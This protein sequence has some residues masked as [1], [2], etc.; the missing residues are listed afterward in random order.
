MELSRGTPP[1]SHPPRGSLDSTVYVLVTYGIYFAA[2]ATGDRQVW[3]D[4]GGSRYGW[5]SVPAASASNQTYVSGSTF[6]PMTASSSFTVTVWQNS[7]GNL[8]IGNGSSTL[9]NRC[10]VMVL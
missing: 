6:L 4:Y 8:I 1:P 2:N 10:Q 5:Q 3:I 7:G 9:A